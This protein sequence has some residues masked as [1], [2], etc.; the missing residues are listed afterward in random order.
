[1]FNETQ[2]ADVAPTAAVKAA[3][4]EVQTKVDPMMDAWRQLLDVDLP[5][6]NQQL[7]AA[8]FDTIKPAAS[9]K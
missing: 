9:D 8:G 1:L 4:A 6:V 5:A 2:G 7:M 3:A